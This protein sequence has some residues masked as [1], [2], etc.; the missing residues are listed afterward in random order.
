MTDFV[1]FPESAEAFSDL[2]ARVQE[3]LDTETRL[4]A[5]PFLAR[6]GFATIYEYDRLLGGDFGA[7]LQALAELHGD[8]DVTVLGLE[9]EAS[10]YRRSYDYFPGFHIDRDSISEGYSLGLRREPGGDSAGALAYTLN[11][12]AIVGSSGAWSVWGQRDWEIGI[13]LT[14]ESSGPWLEVPVAWYGRDLDLDSIRSPAGW[15]M[16][17]TEEDRSTFWHN[18]RE[19]GSG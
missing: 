5:W 10:Y 16:P 18:V 14:P 1:S 7:V 9:P 19:R 12:I 4:P 8:E 13:L 3:L 2:Q 6:S 17:L 15:G 11:V